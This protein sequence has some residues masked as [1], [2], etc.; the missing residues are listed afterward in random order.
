MPV[1]HSYVN[2][3][4]Y[5]ITA[6]PSDVGNI[7][8]QTTDEADKLIT[9]L[10]YEDGDDLP[11]GLINPLR[12][13]G[14]IFT[15]GQGVEADLEDAPDLE[16]S[17]IVNL[18]SEEAKKLLSYFDSRGDIPEDVYAQLRDII[19][20]E[21]KDDSELLGD[22]I[23]SEFECQ[24]THTKL[25]WKTDS[26]EEITRIEITLYGEDIK[27]VLDVNSNNSSYK[28]IDEWTVIHEFGD[29]WEDM[30]RAY[31]TRPKV[32]RAIGAVDD[33]LSFDL[34]YHSGDDWYMV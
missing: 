14:L 28:Y 9:E 18:S 21:E 10:D 33:E 7:T 3:K 31:E 12:S 34:M 29:S 17:E 6:R 19:E 1:F 16:P 30:A 2:K 22:A 23:D 25:I 5:Y 32:M 15:N 13:A 4:G 11:W 8:Y 27:H 20:G 24:K 26:Y